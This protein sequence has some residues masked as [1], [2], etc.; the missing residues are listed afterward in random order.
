MLFE[1]HPSTQQPQA[2][3]RTRAIDDSTYYQSKPAQPLRL[4]PPQRVAQQGRNQQQIGGV[5]DGV[6]YAPQVRLAI[7]SRI[8]EILL[9]IG[10]Q[11]GTGAKENYSLWRPSE[12][13][14]LLFRRRL[15]PQIKNRSSL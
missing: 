9:P 8:S 5:A 1:G 7:P 3:P 14:L 11:T 10:F 2:P 6:P 12:K 13:G 4:L 15:E